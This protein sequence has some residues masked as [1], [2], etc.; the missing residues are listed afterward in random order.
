MISKILVIIVLSAGLAA[1]PMLA[2]AGGGGG[3]ST[4]TGALPNT[5]PATNEG[6]IMPPGTTG[7]GA[8][9]ESRFNARLYRSAA[10]CLNAATAAHVSLSACDSL[11]NR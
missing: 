10:D 3:A 4:A 2:L 9:D 11:H 7:P 5:M 1:L 6:T 8:I